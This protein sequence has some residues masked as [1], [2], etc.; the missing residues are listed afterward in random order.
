MTIEQTVYAA[1]IAVLPNAHADTLPKRPTWPALTFEIES[2]PETGWCQG[3][4]Y[5]QHV[6]TVVILSK[7]KEQIGQ[8]RQ[9]LNDAME[10]VP[11]FLGL[12]EHG[13]A[14]YEGDPDVYAYYMNFRIR[15]RSL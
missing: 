5:D 12:E 8:L 7:S 14:D 13:T 4:G 15:T 10:A 3:G 11:G 2:D 6:I 9:Q 1:L